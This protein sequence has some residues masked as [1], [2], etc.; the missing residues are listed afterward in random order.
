MSETSAVKHQEEDVKISTL[1]GEDFLGLVLK[2]RKEL[3]AERTNDV[4]NLYHT[5]R[6]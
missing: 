4:S 3:E 1:K 6:R 5:K 2:Y